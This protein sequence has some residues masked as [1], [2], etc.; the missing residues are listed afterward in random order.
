[1]S[2]RRFARPRLG[3]LTL[4]AI[5]IAFGFCSG[6]EA[7][8]KLTT[9]PTLGALVRTTLTNPGDAPPTV[10]AG[11]RAT[12]DILQMAYLRRDPAALPNLMRRCFDP[13][14]S[15]LMMGTDPIE[16]VNGYAQ[17]GN[18]IAHDLR[19]WGGVH[20]DVADAQVSASG[21]TAWLATVGTVRFGS[22]LRPIRFTAVL[23]F[24]GD[25][26][27]FRQIQYQYDERPLAPLEVLPSSR[28]RWR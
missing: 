20:L 6:W 21:A 15:V 26:W 19:G 22:T 28:K 16:W 7:S 11:V 13:D 25:H 3:G 8:R 10:R 5:A 2:L 23:T 12:L 18:F 17:A 1:M 4:A 9:E 24:K 27:V 14:L